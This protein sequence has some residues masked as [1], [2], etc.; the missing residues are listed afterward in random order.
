MIDIWDV[1]STSL[2]KRIKLPN[3]YIKEIRVGQYNDKLRLV[4]DG[5]KSQWPP[6]QIDRSEDQLVLSL[7][8]GVQPP[9]PQIALPEKSGKGEPTVGTQRR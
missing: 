8:N 9:V 7:G 6:Y 1:N 2:K 4:F 3:P 5:S